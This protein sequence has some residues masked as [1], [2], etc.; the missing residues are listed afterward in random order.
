MKYSSIFDI[1]K[2]KLPDPN[3]DMIS[4]SGAQPSLESQTSSGG[5]TVLVANA[6]KD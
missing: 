4:F 3:G 6:G 1:V 5:G 2:L